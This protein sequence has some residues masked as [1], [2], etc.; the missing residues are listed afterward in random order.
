M[1][2]IRPTSHDEPKSQWH[3]PSNCYD[4]DLTTYGYD[5]VYGPPFSGYYIEFNVNEIQCNRIRF[6]ARSVS[7]DV[8][9]IDIDVYYSGSWHNVFYR[10]HFSNEVWVEVGLGG[11]Y[12]ITKARV[13]FFNSDV[14]FVRQGRLY[15]FNFYEIASEVGWINEPYAYDDNTG[16][17]A[18]CITLKQSWTP[19]LVR[20]LSEAVYSSV[21]KFYAQYEGVAGIKF[22]DLNVYYDGAW[23][24]VFEGSYMSKV[25]IE[26]ALG[27]T[28][29][30]NKIAVRFY[31]ASLNT[32]TAYIQ[33]MQLVE[34]TGIP[35]VTTN[36]ATAVGDG[37]VTL[38]GNITCTGG[39]DCTI[40]GFKY[41]EGIGG[42]EQDA[43]EEGSFSI[44]TFSED[45][46]GLDP[47]KKYYFKAYAI[48]TSGTGYGEWK[49]FGEDTVIPTVTTS[50]ATLI[51]HEK[52]VLNGNITETG[53]D[54]PGERGF[55]YK[56]GGETT[57]L[58]IRE[59]GLFGVGAYSLD[60]D[61][62]DPNIE[63]HFRAYAKNGAG[64]AYGNWLDFSTEH[65]TPM[66]KTHNATNELITQVTGNGKIISTG[67]QDCN[68]RGFEYGLSK[69]ATW[70]KKEVAGGYGVGFFDIVIDGLTAN[71]EYWYRAFAKFIL[72]VD[73]TKRTTSS[74]NKNY[75]Q[76]QVI[77]DDIYI[78]WEQS[79]QIYLGTMKTDGSGWSA[80]V[81]TS[82]SYYKAI[83]QFHIVGDKIYYVW[84]ESDGSNTQIWT[85]LSDLDGSSFVSTKQTTSAIDRS[86]PQLQVVG[87]K[88]YYVYQKSVSGYLALWLATTDL[89]GTNWS[90]TQV[91]WQSLHGIY[92]P[93]F[94]VVGEK[95]YYVFSKRISSSFGHDGFC[96]GYS[97]LDGSNFWWTYGDSDSTTHIEPSQL[98]VVGEKIY[99]VYGKYNASD[100]YHQIM[101]ASADL[102][103][104]NFSK[105]KKTTSTVSKQ[106]PQLEVVGNKIHYVWH[107]SDGSK[108]QIWTAIMDIDGGNWYA[109]KK[110]TSAYNKRY[111]QLHVVGDELIHYVWSGYDGSYYQIWTSEDIS[112]VGY[113]EWL[114]FITA[115]EGE[116]PTGT[117][118][119]I[120]SDY[121]GCTYRTQASEKDDGHIYV[122]YFV[123][124]TDLT[125]KKGLAYY[126]R[127]L[128]LH[129]YFKS[130]VSGTAI[131][132]VKRDSEP[133]WQ[134]VGEVTLTGIGEILIKHLAPKIRAKHFLLKVSATN[135]FKFLGCLFE[136]IKEGKR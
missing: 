71:T 132:E 85:A 68:E 51:G 133:A 83:P 88:I 75:P 121:S 117:K 62:L 89:D 54:D 127:I 11:T 2:W 123:I 108:M 66:V 118:K 19:W 101:V 16:S 25:W 114:K 129:L 28:Y 115:A 126:K 104:S 53:G 22:I 44:G 92:K 122:A 64:T 34:S 17:E 99:Y 57:I 128:D 130:E 49:S 29:F 5:D 30:V 20:E 55:Q 15:E 84:Y 23:H 96:I 116:I 48:N 6:N 113:G 32:V 41:K 61:G 9:K 67:G 106:S 1:G 24:D 10:G 37:E 12:T 105:T 7:G 21:V 112:Y 98:Q 3:N 109:T 63:Y 102:D 136:S 100:P 27:D 72:G 73:A 91:H 42:G 93:Q 50:A 36:A 47:I 80:T 125:N 134:E 120:C 58:T 70:V 65:T 13:R 110:T 39:V 33:E 103:G 69:V 56:I 124:S 4:G 119:V 74:T 86:R 77:D 97:D 78:I 59:T 76:L 46:S 94:E 14:F 43:H 111:S 52:A 131:V 87:T 40:R 82:G 135:K 18:S 26:K 81:L 35:K 31:N 95:I 107:E 79:S 60:F 90:A 38:N 8:D 45:L